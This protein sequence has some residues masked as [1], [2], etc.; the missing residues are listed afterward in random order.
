MTRNGDAFGV[1]ENGDQRRRPAVVVTRK[2]VEALAAEGLIARQ[3]RAVYVLSEAGRSAAA[4][5]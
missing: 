4:A 5:S 2:Q 3:A 1:N